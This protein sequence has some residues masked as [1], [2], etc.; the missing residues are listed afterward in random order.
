MKQYD[1]IIIGGGASGL[2]GAIAAKRAAPSC[3][4]ALLERQQQIGKKLLATGNGR[5]NLLNRF[6]TPN[7]YHGSGVSLLK[8]IYQTKDVPALVSFLDSIGI[9]ITE[10]EDGKCYPCSLQASSVLDNLRLMAEHLGVLTFCDWEATRL[11]RQ[12][13]GFLVSSKEETLFGRRVIV[14]AGNVASKH[15]GGTDLGLTLLQQ[16]SHTI[17]PFLPSIVQL[18]TGG[19]PK[20]LSGIKINGTVSLLS[21][22]NV[23][24]REYGEILF[25]D[26]GLSGPPVLQ[27]SGA[28]SRLL[29]QNK[30]GIL[31]LDLFPKQS[32]EELIEIL[33]KRKA[34]FSDFP[35][36]QFFSG[37]LHKKLSLSVMKSAGLSPLS[38]KGETLNEPELLNLAKTAKAFSF[39]LTGTNGFVNAQVTAGGALGDEFSKTTL[40]SKKAKGLFACGEVLDVDGDCGGFNL[41]WAWASGLTAGEAAAHSILEGSYDRRT[42]R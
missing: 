32:L 28:A 18:K 42:S 6:P 4:T 19:N 1:I 7:R 40:E 37:L 38:R 25:T 5:C 2:A 26:Y 15:L 14:A 13:D 30:E 17:T 20:A 21:S 10:E 36:E 11:Q 22:G 31:S 34:L 9:P 27:L 16:M 23:V 29:S 33:K 8:A 35:L 41:T 3:E 24:Q 12:K 39:P